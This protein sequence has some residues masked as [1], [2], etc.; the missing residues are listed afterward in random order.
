VGNYVGKL[1]KSAII[2]RAVMV[3]STLLNL[4]ELYVLWQ[5]QQSEV[6]PRAASATSGL[7]LQPPGQMALADIRVAPGITRPFL[8][9][10]GLSI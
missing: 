2:G 7:M 9:R 8:S 10:N 6:L 3:G 1:A 5:Q 4:F